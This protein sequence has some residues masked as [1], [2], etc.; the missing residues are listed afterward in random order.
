MSGE[1]AIVVSDQHLG[2]EGNSALTGSNSKDF[3][4]F[5]DYLSSRDDVK[6]LIILGDFI[7]MWRRDASGLFL[8]CHDFIEKILA[9]E[10]NMDVQFV[11]GNHD[12][13]LKNLKNHKY[14]FVFQER[15]ENWYLGK[16]KYT[17]KHGWEYDQPDQNPIMMEALCYNFS[18]DAGTIRSD[19]YGTIQREMDALKNIFEGHGGRDAYLDDIRKTPEER[20]AS[21]FS[22]VEDNAF[23]DL[24]PDEVLIFGH[25]HRPFISDTGRLANSGSWVR[26][27][28]VTNTF[29]ELDDAGQVRLFVFKSANYITEIKD[30]IHFPRVHTL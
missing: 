29:L 15:I 6:H 4:S 3:L 10:K 9:L 22:K 27:A 18:D 12:Y 19:I 24:K 16:T 1:K 14:P 28:Q 7:D 2:Y 26:D 20:L 5:L 8:E 25:T 30:R 21:S 11:A 23:N 17:F 13:H